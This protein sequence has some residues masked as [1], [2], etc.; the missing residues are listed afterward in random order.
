MSKDVNKDF[1]VF[2]EDSSKLGITQ[3][4]NAENRAE[5]WDSAKGKADFKE[6]AFGEKQTMKDDIT[7]NVLH[8]SQKAA[9]NK[10]HQKNDEGEIVSTA[11][12]D[13]AAETDHINAIKDVHDKAKHNPF[14]TDQDFKE[15]VNS[16]SNYRVIP[17]SLNASKGEKSDWQVI[18][19]FDNDVTL[20]GRAKMAGEKIRADTAMH[21]NFAIRTAKNAGGEF[22]KGAADSV[23][24]N[25]IPLTITAIENMVEAAQGEKSFGEAV[26]DTGKTVVDIAVVGGVDKLMEYI[27]G[28]SEIAAISQV[29]MIVKDS[30]VRYVNGEISEKEFLEEIGT[31]GTVMVAQMLGGSIG[32]ELGM[33]IGAALGTVIA[34]GAGTAIGTVVGRQVGEFLGSLI[35]TAACS[36]ILTAKDIL[37]HI[38]DYKLKES[39]FARLANNAISEIDNQRDKLKA[40]IDKDDEKWKSTVD[41]SFEIIYNGLMG[42]DNM[43]DSFTEITRGLDKIMSMFGSHAMFH[44]VEE[45]DAEIDDV[46]II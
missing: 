39:E 13:H 11:W 25:V 40:I 27:P 6:K 2:N 31:E 41:E 10:Y 8:K 43:D 46:L 1:N 20:K 32:Q 3:D 28:S 5:L 26:K 30:A 4:Y 33:F 7:S 36:A 29:A 9:K 17:K 22:T 34:P 14:L 24:D 19:D 35:A 23:V 42:T 16:E 15:V 45:Y 21:A 12:A 18:A 44:S 37:K 38:D